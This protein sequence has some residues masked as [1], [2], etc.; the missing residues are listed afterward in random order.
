MILKFDVRHD[1]GTGV[2]MLI[3]EPALFCAPDSCMLLRLAWSPPRSRQSHRYRY[4]GFG[5]PMIS[6]FQLLE[7]EQPVG[8][9][10][11]AANRYRHIARGVIIAGRG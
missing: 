4:A 1:R 8:A 11:S 7:V 5:S 10:G 9:T 6:S 2:S 3:R